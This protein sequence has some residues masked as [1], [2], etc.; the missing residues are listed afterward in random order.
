MKLFVL[1]A[2]VAVAAATA[3]FYAR[4][5]GEVIEGEYIIV[6]K[7]I[8][9]DAR[10]A[11]Y[12]KFTLGASE[13]IMH[14][15]AFTGFSGYSAKLE[16]ETVTALLEDESV[17]YVEVN[18]MAHAFACQTQSN[19][20]QGLWGLSRTVQRSLPNQFELE[21]NDQRDRAV[22]V[23]I[24]DTGVRCT[25]VD[26][27]NRPN[28]C[29]QGHDSTGEGPGDGNGH[30]TH[31]AGTVAG[32]TYGFCKECE[33]IDVKVLGRNGSGSFAGVIAGID[34]TANAHGNNRRSVGNMSLGGGFSAAVNDATN[35]AVA[36]GVNYAVASGNSNTNACNTSPASAAQ[37]V[38]VNSMTNT[39]ARSSFSNIGTCTDI[40]APGSNVLSA[41]ST[42]DTATS[43]ISGTSMASPHVA[44]IL[45]E[46]VAEPG[47]PETPAAIK[48]ELIATATSGTVTNPGTGSPNELLFYSCLD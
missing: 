2:L 25:H 28:R 44:G 16:K 29:S 40:F 32:N 30:G 42:S 20:P 33:I 41:W 17:A 18:Q 1:A 9:A 24:L 23:F 4:E 37:A 38:T 11:H 3:P 48:A 5:G 39:D 19:L 47:R 45:A 15:Y 35:A 8:D 27:N 43:T 26:F 7:D 6:F 10:D 36:A 12:A 14:K 13:S 22:D 21:Y 46:M 31:V 34:Y